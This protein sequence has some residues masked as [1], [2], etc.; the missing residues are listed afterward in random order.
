MIELEKS[1]TIFLSL[2]TFNI[3]CC[4]LPLFLI[5]CPGDELNIFFTSL[6]LPLRFQILLNS[7]YLWVPWIPFLSLNPVQFLQVFHWKGPLIR[8][9]NVF[10]SLV[11]LT[12]LT[13]DRIAL[14]F[15]WSNY[16]LSWRDSSECA[17]LIASIF[18][19]IESFISYYFPSSKTHKVWGN[20]TCSRAGIFPLG[21]ITLF[22]LPELC[23]YYFA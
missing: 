12:G 4:F 13:R 3:W 11:L 1:P 15:L 16:S 18:S 6:Y 17:K 14:Y 5:N 9:S 20:S 7:F 8:R 10:S 22:K 21:I 2:I 23:E 19:V